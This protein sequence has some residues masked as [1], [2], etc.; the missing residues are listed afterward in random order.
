MIN[1][2]FEAESGPHSSEVLRRCRLTSAFD[3]LSGQSRVL[4]IQVHRT[5]LHARL[6]R[7][8]SSVGVPLQAL[9]VG[10][11]EAAAGLTTDGGADNRRTP[12]R[13]DRRR[14]RTRIRRRPGSPRSAGQDERRASSGIAL[15]GARQLDA[16][17]NIGRRR[18]D[19]AT[20]GAMRV[21]GSEVPRCTKRHSPARP[22]GIERSTGIRL[23][24]RRFSA[25]WSLAIAHHSTVPAPMRRL[26]RGIAPERPSREP[27]DG[28]HG[29]V[30][31]HPR[32]CR[33]PTGSAGGDL[34]EGDQ[35]NRPVF[36]GPCPPG[37]EHRPLITSRPNPSPVELSE[38]NL[39]RM[40][41]A[42]PGVDAPSEERDTP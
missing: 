21:A 31:R 13:G 33:K 20:A 39:G 26:R 28:V 17:P 23:G 7:S 42:Y 8:P 9:L 11:V 12:Y 19:G 16:P 18:F 41:A 5:H 10:N 4:E 27:Q 3:P 6:W 35:P 29:R 25:T 15:G 14:R 36:S 22:G 40:K 32:A 37:Y 2:R 38:L 24:R 34:G 1:V 30:D